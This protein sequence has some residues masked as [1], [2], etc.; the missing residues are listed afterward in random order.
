M[1][2]STIIQHNGYIGRVRV[3]ISQCVHKLD[4]GY[5][6][7]SEQVQFFWK[8]AKNLENPEIS[9]KIVI[10]S[11]FENDLGTLT[12]SA[13]CKK[14]YKMAHRTRTPHAWVRYPHAVSVSWL[15]GYIGTDFGTSY[16][17]IWA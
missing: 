14:T 7:Q 3:E 10:F 8:M 15:V 16:G 13:R 1:A 6:S 4:V 12:S 11:D 5:E 9:P 2:C 17:D